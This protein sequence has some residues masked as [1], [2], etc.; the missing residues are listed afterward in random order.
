MYGD[1]NLSI[2]LSIMNKHEN[3]KIEMPHV[4]AARRSSQ[5]NIVKY[6]EVLIDT[7]DVSVLITE[8][9]TNS[10]CLKAFKSLSKTELVEQVHETLKYLL[11][12]IALKS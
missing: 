10:V 4:R 6:L 8:R 5:I 2:Y 1:I 12:Q 7:L 11:K 3:Q 9:S